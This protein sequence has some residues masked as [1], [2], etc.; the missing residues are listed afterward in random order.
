MA[1]E[2][3]KEI[4][5]EGRKFRLKFYRGSWG[6]L[7]CRGYEIKSFSIFKKNIECKKQLFEF[8]TPN[9]ECI[10]EIAEDELQKILKR[11]KE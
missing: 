8:W 6:C 3:I 4:E 10:I 2:W 5:L 9:E 11:K 1:K 7:W